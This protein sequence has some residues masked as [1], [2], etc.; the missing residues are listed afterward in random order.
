MKLRN[1]DDFHEAMAW[2]L[3]LV[4]LV[5]ALMSM[6]GCASRPL[7]SAPTPAPG[8][9]GT[10]A[11]LGATLVWVGGIVSTVGVVGRVILAAGGGFLA[12]IPGVS[13][14]LIYAVTGGLACLAVG[15][16][17]IYLSENLWILWVTVVLSALAWAGLHIDDLR[18]WGRRWLAAG[19]AK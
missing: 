19:K 13:G 4:G 3:I 5:I 10:L 11:A 1:P 18:R 7:T 14:I 8:P 2:T 17:F 16:S 9:G 12:L 15:S 6:T